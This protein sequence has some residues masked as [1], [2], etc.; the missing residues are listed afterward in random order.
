MLQIAEAET[1]QR[2]LDILAQGQPVDVLL[3]DMVMPGGMTG[4]ELA[5]QVRTKYPNIRVAFASGYAEGDTMPSDMPS[6]GTPWLRKPY[7][8]HQ[9]ARTLRELLDE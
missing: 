1:G 7:T 4:A 8:L 9:L 3:T 6:D 2:A 5:H